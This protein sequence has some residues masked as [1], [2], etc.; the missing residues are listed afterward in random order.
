MGI[1]KSENRSPGT[2]VNKGQGVVPVVCN[3]RGWMCVWIA[4][5]DICFCHL[6]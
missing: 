1:F 5:K 4:L 2:D 3:V 6:Y